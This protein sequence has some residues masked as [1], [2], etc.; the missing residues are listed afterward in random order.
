MVCWRYAFLCIINALYICGYMCRC[1]RSYVRSESVQFLI[2]T[3]TRIY[4]PRVWR[5]QPLTYR[6]RLD[7]GLRKDPIGPFS[8]QPTIVLTYYLFSK[9][10]I[11]KIQLNI[12]TFVKYIFKSLYFSTSNII[13][14]TYM[15]T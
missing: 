4:G 12:H 3:R 8:Y 6:Y 13:N 9:L 11:L 15:F 14:C 10:N 5:G 7:K 2:Y 1:E